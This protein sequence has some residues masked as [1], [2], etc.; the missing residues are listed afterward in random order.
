M[1]I[2]EN[3]RSGLPSIV[4]DAGSNWGPIIGG[5]LRCFLKKCDEK[6]LPKMCDTYANTISSMCV[7]RA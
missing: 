1:S 2:L 3:M 6:K 7:Q 5:Q 4:T